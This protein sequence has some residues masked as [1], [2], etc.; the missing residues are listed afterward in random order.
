MEDKDLISLKLGGQDDQFQIALVLNPAIHEDWRK[1]NDQ[2][3]QFKVTDAPKRILSGYAMIADLNIPRVDKDGN[4]FMV[5]FSKEN[6]REIVYN[7]FRNSLVKNFNENHQT[8]KLSEGVF[9][10]E[11]LFIDS[12]RGINCPQGFTQVA[13]GSWFISIK[14]ENED[15][16]KRVEAGDYKGFSV[17]SREFVAEKF[18]EVNAFLDSLKI[19]K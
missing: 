13:D 19:T 11:S 8:G 7:F 2:N 18:C 16:W 17:E 6:I 14:I 15:V 1:F 5:A 12:T 10:F 9:L 4:Q 3:F